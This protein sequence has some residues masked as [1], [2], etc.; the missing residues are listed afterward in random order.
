[1]K[2]TE[3]FVGFGTRLWSVRKGETEYGIKVLPL[4]G[5]VKI[6]GMNSLEQVDPADEPRTYRQQPFWRRLSVAVAGSTMHFL[7]ALVLLFAIFFVHRGPGLLRSAAG[8]NDGRRAR[9]P[10]QR[11]QPGPDGRLPAWAT[12]SCPS[13][14]R[15]FATED[16]LH[17]LPAQASPTRRST[18][19]SGERAASSTSTRRTVDLSKVQA[20]RRRP[21]ARRRRSPSRP[22]SSGFAPEPAAVRYGF[23]ASI[24]Q[25]G[26]RLRRPG[27]QDLRR[28][29][30]ACSAPTGCRPTPT[31]WSTRRPPTPPGALRFESPGRHRAAGP[32]R[33]PRP[34]SRTSLFLLILIN[35]FVGI[36]NMVP[37]LP[38]DGG[39]VA[40]AIYE[41]ARSRKGRRYYADA[42]KMMPFVYATLAVI[43]FIGASALFLDS[44]R[45]PDRSS[46][47]E[48]LVTTTVAIARAGRTGALGPP[49]DPADH[50]RRGAR[51]RRGAGVGAV[52]DD[53]QDRRRRRHPG[54]DLRPARRGRRHR[55]LHLQR[56]GGR[57]GAGPDRAPL[58]GADHRRH[59]LP[60]GDGV[61]RPGGRGR[62]ACASTPATSASP[63][64]SSWWPGSAGTGG[65]RCVSGS[66]PGRS[67]PGCTTSTAGRRPRPWWSRPSIELALFA[68]VDF[69]DVKISVKASNV[70]LMIEA[71]RQLSAVTDHPL[72]LG[73]TEAG[74]PPA[75]TIKA[76][77]GIA[78]L[79]AEGIGDTIRYSLTADP[80]EEVKAGRPAAGGPG[81]AGTQERRPDRL[82]ELRPGRDR[83]LQGGP[84]GPGGAGGPGAAHPGGGHGLRGQRSGRGPLA[85]ISASPP[86]ATGATCSSRARS[87]GWCPRTRWSKRWW[88]RPRSW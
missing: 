55:A 50:G 28:P 57:R 11:A 63:R 83:R 68:E 88:R 19:W 29:R 2:V 66:T 74:P 47:S 53:H 61:G 56:T 39:H 37:L 82:P 14:A 12:A 58:A 60:R 27:G 42:A 40:V 79:L 7:I 85:P 41:A 17:D 87:C 9:R 78:T 1:M 65:C 70:P 67:I 51:G 18:S 80:V 36:F 49:A 73:V 5:Y 76:T 84:G 75:G 46:G 62:R 35:I 13:T 48:R 33:R 69:A 8:S 10:G 3:F 44:P 22:A 77:A 6:L 25:V 24:E 31:C 72:H 43:V 86:G 4:G 23:V 21:P 64:R 54:P 26:R 16:A 81:P 20:Q 30:A 59:P 71:Y 38:L 32:H 52:D 45:R 34:G 15:V